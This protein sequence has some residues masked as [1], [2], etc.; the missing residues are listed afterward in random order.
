MKREAYFCDTELEDPYL[1]K[2]GLNDL[3]R[4]AEAF[5]GEGQ[6]WH[7]RGR[8]NTQKRRVY[9]PEQGER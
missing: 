2:T 7:F 3:V 6:V 1:L 9:A 8:G 5:R 4:W